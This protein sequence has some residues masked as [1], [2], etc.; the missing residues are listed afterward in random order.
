M[1]KDE[2]ERKEKLEKITE[3]WKQVS[4]KMKDEHE[5]NLIET[6]DGHRIIK[7]LN[8]NK[9]A[10][11]LMTG[12]DSPENIVILGNAIDPI[13]EDL[14]KDWCKGKVVR[15]N[16]REE[17]LEFIQ[18]TFIKIIN[19]ENTLCLNEVYGFVIGG[20]TYVPKQ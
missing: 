7:V 15:V 19:R 3:L 10:R 11:N 16:T 5:K 2:R 12:L 13:V 6:Y 1:T 20:E 4:Q 17:A 9:D 18:D 8:T 14:L